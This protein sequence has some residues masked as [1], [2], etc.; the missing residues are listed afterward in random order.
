[1]EKKL[2]YCSFSPTTVLFI[3]YFFQAIEFLLIV[4]TFRYLFYHFEKI[5]F[6]QEL[7][8]SL[9]S[10]SI[11][12]YFAGLIIFNP[13]IAS[14]SDLAGRRKT[15]IS[16]QIL[17]II[18]FFSCALGYYF[19]SLFI[20][21]FSRLINGISSS[22]AS[23][24]LASVADLYEDPLKRLKSYGLIQIINGSLM[25]F[26]FF[27]AATAPHPSI[28][29]IPSPSQIYLICSIVSLFVLLLLFSNFPETLKEAHD[30]KYSLSHLSLKLVPFFKTQQIKSIYFTYFILIYSISSLILIESKFLY[31]RIGENGLLIVFLFF[32]VL[33]A[34]VSH[35]GLSPL[36]RKFNVKKITLYSSILLILS[37]LLSLFF[38]SLSIPI[39]LLCSLILGIVMSAFSWI[40]GE[41][42]PPHSRGF[43]FG[44]N[45]SLWAFALL[46]SFFYPLEPLPLLLIVTFLIAVSRPRPEI[47]DRIKTQYTDR[48]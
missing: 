31:S 28:E 47:S 2:F 9:I 8:N 16:I 32:I 23:I 10:Y 21:L 41:I 33:L 14:F 5:H 7:H 19:I 15:L 45:Q 20:Y 37:D 25:A 18:S 35:F 22:F 30:W 40:L 1:M 27:L 43:S 46:L 38:P 29:P 26:F 3:G 39:L 24:S 36:F 34:L 17:R 42:V 48:E 12:A 6:T 11:V 44:W 13:L 4:P